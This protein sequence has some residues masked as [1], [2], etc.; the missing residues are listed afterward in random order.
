[1]PR[2]K[3][4]DHQLPVDLVDL[5]VEATDAWVPEANIAIWVSAYNGGKTIQGDRKSAGQWTR[6]QAHFLGGGRDIAGQMGK[7]RLSD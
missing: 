2:L 5:A 4:E 7:K 3:V 6:C 1:M